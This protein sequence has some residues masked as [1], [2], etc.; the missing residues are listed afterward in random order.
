MEN[1]YLRSLPFSSARPNPMKPLKVSEYITPQQTSAHSRLAQDF[2][3][4]NILR[5]SY[6]GFQRRGHDEKKKCTFEDYTEDLLMISLYNDEAAASQFEEAKK[7][8]AELNQN[9]LKCFTEVHK[10]VVHDAQM[11]FQQ[12][13]DE[14]KRWSERYDMQKLRDEF[15]QKIQLVHKV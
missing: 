10:H 5:N 1:H 14:F 6:G 7:A 4:E 3:K 2:S 13:A 9:V 8:I 15:N 12:L 11:V